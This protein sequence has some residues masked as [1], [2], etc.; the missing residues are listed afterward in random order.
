M[1]HFIYA[2]LAGALLSQPLFVRAEQPLRPDRVQTG[3]V[4]NLYVKVANGVF[5]DIRLQR[6]RKPLETWS[7]AQL[8][9]AGNGNPRNY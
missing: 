6:D 7:D 1:K 2:L 8:R 3:A 9:D 5:M 4:E